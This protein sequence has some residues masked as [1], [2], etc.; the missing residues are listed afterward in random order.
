MEVNVGE[1]ERM[2]SAIVGGALLAASPTRAR[3]AQVPLAL[4]GL[5]MLF[6]A[7]SGRCGVYQA[8]G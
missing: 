8:L 2:V 4:A 6:R 1:K 3:W 5:G 7:A